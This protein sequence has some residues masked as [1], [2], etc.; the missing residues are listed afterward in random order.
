MEDIL[1][2]SYRKFQKSYGNPLTNF[3]K[4]PMP[5]IVLLILLLITTLLS[6]LMG[7]ISCLKPYAIYGMLA[8]VSLCGIVY[9]YTEHFQIKSSNTRLP[10]YANYCKDVLNWLNDCKVITTEENISKLL[11]RAVA[12]AKAEDE[13]RT[14]LRTSIEK[15]IQSLIVPIILVVFTTII[16]KQENLSTI[17]TSSLML[18]TILF[19]IGIFCAAIYNFFNFYSKRKLEQLKCF[20]DDLQGVLDTQFEQKLINIS[21]SNNEYISE[22]AK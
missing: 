17:L 10:I 5:A 4:I 8:E 19:F 7:F 11:N 6:V 21:E 20:A 13:K 12:T 2:D 15:W 16:G 22:I 9:I 3:K 14:A 1:F 18:L